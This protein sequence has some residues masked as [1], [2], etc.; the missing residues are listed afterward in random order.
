ML[1]LAV[2]VLGAVSLEDKKVYE[3]TGT[4]EAIAGLYVE[5]EV[6]R[7]FQQLGGPDEQDD[8]LYLYRLSHHSKM[9]YIGFGMNREQ[10]QAAYRA[11][12]SSYGEPATHGWRQAGKHTT[13]TEKF[14]VKK[15]PNLASTLEQTM[16][17]GGSLIHDGA[18]GVVC[19][20]QGT[21]KWIM[22]TSG[23]ERICDGKKDCKK[24]WDESCGKT[25]QKS[26]STMLTTEITTKAKI[27]VLVPGK[28][29]TASTYGDTSVTTPSEEEPESNDDSDIF[30]L[31]VDQSSHEADIP[32]DSSKLK[33]SC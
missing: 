33:S 9:W 28:V 27:A 22:M 25:T 10:I 29:S 17:R 14:R 26:T 6:P 23:D 18:G 31:D 20:E 12:G 3:V 7:I 21:D 5:T 2:A 15:K 4:D 1:F 30:D 13:R 11:W 32:S 19:L 24:N 8:F 16:E